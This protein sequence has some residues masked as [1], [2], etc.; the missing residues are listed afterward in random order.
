MRRCASTVGLATRV[1]GRPLDPR[2][3]HTLPL[4][5]MAM[6]GV[7]AIASLYGG[8]FADRVGR[9]PVIAIGWLVHALVYAAFAFVS[10]V[11]AI[12][13]LFLLYGAHRGLTGGAERALVSTLV[14]TSHAGTGFGWYH[15]TVGLLTLAA[16]VLFG[17]LWSRFDSQ[18]A[19]LSSAILA[20][21]ATAALLAVRLPKTYKKDD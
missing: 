18:V 6:H 16:N 2:T 21:F 19:F 17:V 15:L 14:S 10:D 9:R 1:R 7:K 20:L 13:A 4:L 12:W 11:W 5:W 3:V 8:R